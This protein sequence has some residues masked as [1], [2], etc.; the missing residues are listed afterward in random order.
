MHLIN[1]K[2]RK[3][4]KIGEVLKL[5]TSSV[6]SIKKDSLL[7]KSKFD[8]ISDLNKNQEYFKALEEALKLLEESKKLKSNYWIFK[9]NYLIAEIYRKTN[10]FQKA[11][12][13]FNQS[14]L[15][16]R[17]SKVDKNY[18]KFSD[19]DYF[20]S[21]LQ[22]GTSYHAMHVSINFN[23]N[24]SKKDSIRLAYKKKSYIDSAMAIYKKIEK[25]PSVNREVEVLKGTAFNNIS[26]IYEED[27]L[28]TKAEYY[29]LKAIE[30]HK[31]N[32]DKLKI[33]TSLNKLGNISLSQKKY[34]KAKKIYIE[35]IELIKYNNNSTAIR[36]KANLYYNLAWAMRNLEEFEAYD[37]Q[38]KF[39]EIEENE[40]D[41]EFRGIIEEIS[42]KYDVDVAESRVRQEEENKRL[43]SQKF[44]WNAAI[45]AVIV[46]ISLAYWLALNSLKQKN[47]ALSLSQTKLI[48]D[49]NIEKLKS[50]SQVR[51]LNATIDG[52]ESERK[53]IAETLHDS[54][55]ALLSSANLH[56]QAT[57][58]QFTN[59]PVEIDKTQEIILEASQKIRD[60][61]HTLVSSVLLKF[62]LTFAIKDIAEKY[63]NSELNIETEI[64]NVDRY[65][66]N[67]E[68]KVYN[69]IQE[70][71]NNILKHSKA[72]N[73]LI[74]LEQKAET[75]FI[76]ISD[77]GIGFDKIKIT[78]KDGLGL[79]QIDAR[80]Q[81]M[82][83]KFKIDSSKN[84]GTQISVE[85]PVLE[86]EEPN[87]V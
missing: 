75:L 85:L 30:I 62:G 14:L 15:K 22:L 8:K 70:F 2:E 74:E 37:F 29:A 1:A 38:E 13:Y 81:M 84:N 27:S 35:A 16:I 51:V 39:Y 69:I 33:A 50:E 17:L 25:L 3:K 47:L 71:V 48:Q 42:A 83:G 23:K 34:Q 86:K 41:K 36:R 87:L 59:V 68:I 9:C 20:N 52:K 18:I 28:F 61:S 19:F 77:D 7:I 82:K 63:S 10:R 26:N 6:F 44:F 58:K 80:I 5:E 65:H 54:V 72:D 66:Q 76:T 24:H 57:R 60:L 49:Q 32:K 55:S 11:I 64:N 21:L 12:E 43:K 40:R 45:I 53:Q 67:F 56:L 78:S 46:I 79:N 4:L 73:A 31:K